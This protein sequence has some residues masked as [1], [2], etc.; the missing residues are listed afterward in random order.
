MKNILL[1]AG[2]PKNRSTFLGL[3]IALSALVSLAIGEAFVIDHFKNQRD[4]YRAEARTLHHQLDH[5]SQAAIDCYARK[6]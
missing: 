4:G 1:S 2:V 6:E 5:F 3:S